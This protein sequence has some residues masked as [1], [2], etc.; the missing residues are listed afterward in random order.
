MKG[1]VKNSKSAIIKNSPEY[2]GGYLKHSMISPEYSE[3][4]PKYFVVTHKLCVVSLKHSGIS[5]RHFWNSHKHSV[6]FPRYSGVSSNT[7]WSPPN[8]LGASTN[9]MRV[10]PVICGLP[11]TLWGN[12]NLINN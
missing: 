8:T 3:D 1:V 2:F 9:I 6:D 11:H 10:A 5:P 7:P 12:Y 4:S